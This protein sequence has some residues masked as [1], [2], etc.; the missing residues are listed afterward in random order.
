MNTTL[1]QWLIVFAVVFVVNPMPAFGPANALLLVFFK[2]NWH[3]DPVAVVVLG[4]FSSRAGRYVLAA[5]T[6]RRAGRLSAQR[7]ANPA[8]AGGYLTGSGPQIRRARGV[9]GAPLPVGAVVRSGR[10]HGSSPATVSGSRIRA[11]RIRALGSH[12]RCPIDVDEGWCRLR[13]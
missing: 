12:L 11:S 1:W 2:L 4:A 8:A 7:R 13:G 3:L 10:A 6:N 5:A 9:L